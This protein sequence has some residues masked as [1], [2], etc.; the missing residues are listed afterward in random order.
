MANRRKKRF[1]DS[2][3]QGALFRRIILHWFIFLAII[4]IAL[5]LWR[6]MY[7]T[8]FSQPFSTLML[9]SWLEMAPVF[10]ILLAMLPIFAWDTVTFS[11]RFAGPMYRFQS[12]MKSL[13]AGE[14][15]VPIKLRKG[16]FWKDIAVD[17]NEL[18]KLVDEQRKTKETTAETRSDDVSVEE[19]PDLALPADG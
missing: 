6:V 10:V 18:A 12:A 7:T 11:H 17:I 15:F 9:Q 13:L 8:G 19:E 4:C 3:V 2:A 5:P 14:P 1:I 16:D